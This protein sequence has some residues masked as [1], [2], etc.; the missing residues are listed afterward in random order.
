MSDATDPAMR[1]GRQPWSWRAYRHAWLGWLLVNI[2]LTAGVLW[3]EWNSAPR[4]AAREFERIGGQVAW[5]GDGPALLGMSYLT[6]VTFVRQSLDAD[7]FKRVVDLIRSC[8]ELRRLVFCD[9]P[10]GPS[11]LA[12]LFEARPDITV[13]HDCP[14][15]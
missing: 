13:S 3:A 1:P 10:I 4:R 7:E 8:P 12:D 14:S 15:I 5:Q 2:G 6:G 9:T 11:N